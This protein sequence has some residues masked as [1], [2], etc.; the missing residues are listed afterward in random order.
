ME[1]KYVQAHLALQVKVEQLQAE[2][3]NLKEGIIESRE[4]ES[5]LIPQEL[6][7]KL[8]EAYRWRPVSEP[9]EYIEGLKQSKRI[10]I[11]DYDS[12]YIGDYHNEKF[13][14]WSGSWC[15]TDEPASQKAITHWK[16]IM[17]PE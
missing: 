14:Y 5:I 2:N 7:D 10:F 8:Y 1:E 16:P 6:Y 11:F 17:P 3:E 12:V 13:E 4:T 15:N 9:P